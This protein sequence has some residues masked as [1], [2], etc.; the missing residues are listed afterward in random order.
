MPAFICTTCGTQFSPT[1]LPPASCPICLDERQYIGPAGQ[2]WTE[3][4][5]LRRTHNIVTKELEPSLIGL[6]VEPHFAIG[7]RALLVQSGEGN[8]LWDC[9]SLVDETAIAALRQLGGIKA[10][11]ISHPHYYGAMVSWSE[12][13]GGVPIFLHDADREWAMRTDGNIVFWSGDTHRLADNMTLIRCGGHF[14]GGTV[15]HWPAG[16]AG[17]GAL[18]TGDILQVAADCRHVGFM[19]SY[20]NYIP[21]SEAVVRRI[22][23]RI[24]PYRYDRIY[25]AFWPSIIERDGEATVARSVERY[26]AAIAGQGPADSENDG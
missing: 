2:Q 14:A 8:I 5:S 26:I 23:G 11:A 18:L 16:A 20:P 7:Q 12:A 6:G 22:A 25:G 3:L 15:L 9:L 19:R 24:A 17:K 4:D 10:I 13:F 1:A 21:L